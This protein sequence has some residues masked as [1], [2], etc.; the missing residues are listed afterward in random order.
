MF[1]FRLKCKDLQ[2]KYDSLGNVL[3]DTANDVFN[4]SSLDDSPEYWDTNPVYL[5]VFK[6]AMQEI[7]LFCKRI[8]QS[9]CNNQNYGK[10]ENMT[11]K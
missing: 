10:G 4:P 2:Q 5:K 1:N 9:D 3:T 6:K 11:R 7:Y 8:W